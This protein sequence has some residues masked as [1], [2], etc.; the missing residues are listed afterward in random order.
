MPIQTAIRQGDILVISTDIAPAAMTP[1]APENGRVVLAHGENTGHHHSFALSD[2]VALFREDGTGGGLY[3]SVTGDAPE[4][5]EHQE[6]T[7]HGVPPG[8]H[9]VIRQVQWSDDD[10]PI[11]IED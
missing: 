6:H 9:D 1:V 3:L 10:E 2:T 8:G 5:L 11:Q 4:M 7:A